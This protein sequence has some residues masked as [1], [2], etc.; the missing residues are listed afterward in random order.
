MNRKALIKNNPKVERDIKVLDDAR[1]L[2]D[3]LK[4]MGIQED[5]YRLESPMFYRNIN[6]Q[7]RG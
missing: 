5:G 3:E 1:K 4:K 6:V 7:V 2:V